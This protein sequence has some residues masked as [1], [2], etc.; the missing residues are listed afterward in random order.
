VAFG[1]TIR[2]VCLTYLSDIAPGDYVLVQFGFAVTRLEPA[3]AEET[4][5]LLEGLGAARP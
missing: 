5:A 3:E 2:T 1:D 4:L